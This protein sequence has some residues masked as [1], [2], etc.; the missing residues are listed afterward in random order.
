MRRSAE[1]FVER[2]YRI[3]F[4]ALFILGFVGAVASA[5][6]VTPDISTEE[7][8]RS[9]LNDLRLAEEVNAINEGRWNQDTDNIQEDGLSRIEAILG[10]QPE[11]QTAQK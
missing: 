10:E 11:E 8:S 7:P 6:K 2:L 5:D 3:I 9:L 1:V 4:L